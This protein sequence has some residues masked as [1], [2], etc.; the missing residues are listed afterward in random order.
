MEKY[1]TSRQWVLADCRPRRSK[2]STTWRPSWPAL[3][4]ATPPSPSWSESRNGGAERYAAWPC[5]PTSMPWARR[6]RPRARARRRRRTGPPLP[7]TPA[8]P[9]GGHDL[10]RGHRHPH[11]LWEPGPALHPPSRCRAVPTHTQLQLRD[12][13]SADQGRRVGPSPRRFGHRQ[14]DRSQAPDATRRGHSR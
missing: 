10:W 11:R 2:P 12:L 4:R 9:T 1:D 3:P 5:K 13:P 8:H 6:C 7:Q 14:D